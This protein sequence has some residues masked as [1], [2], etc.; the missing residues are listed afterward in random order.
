MIKKNLRKN[1]GLCQWLVQEFTHQS[2]IKEFFID[3]PI[4]DMARFTAGLLKTAMQTLYQYEKEE[5]DEYINM[6]EKKE[7][8]PVEFIA[9]TQG[10]AFVD[11]SLR[12]IGE[13]NQIYSPCKQVRVVTI[14]VNNT[15]NKL[16][17]LVL[18]INSFL[19]L[20]VSKLA[21]HRILQCSMFHSVINHFAELGSIARLYL[22]KTKTMS[23]LLHIFLNTKNGSS[24]HS[25]ERFMTNKIPLFKLD[26]PNGMYLVP[27]TQP[28]LDSKVR[29]QE[30]KAILQ[31][32]APPYTFVVGTISLLARSC[33]FVKSSTS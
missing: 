16:P 22:L 12:E 23:R 33:E 32:A 27:N 17:M 29:S 10:S 26:F 2:I 1:V 8:D 14:K 6:L 5:L 28:D 3:N 19:H 13:E 7:N 21:I 15:N 25:N 30:R 11:C 4:T 24:Y 20:Q 18:L 9:T 31:Q